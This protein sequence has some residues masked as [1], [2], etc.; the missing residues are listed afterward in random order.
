MNTNPIHYFEIN[1]IGGCAFPRLASH[2][3][4][5]KDR[6]IAAILTLTERSLPVEWLNDFIYLHI[7]VRDFCPPTIEQ[8]H[9]C[10][11]FLKDCL[12]AGKKPVVHCMMGYGRTGTILAAYL[13]SEGM[14]ANEAINKVRGKRP[15]AIETYEQENILFEF[16][17]IENENI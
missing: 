7:P 4:W 1:N 6:G 2:I 13:I 14:T 8:L 11:D 3:K 5:L 12:V 15:G 9:L 16:E 17:A 10:V